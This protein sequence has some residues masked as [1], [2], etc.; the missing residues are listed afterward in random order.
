MCLF[1]HDSIWARFLHQQII[2]HMR[3]RFPEWVH[4]QVVWI[5]RMSTLKFYWIQENQTA[6]YYI[7]FKLETKIMNC[8][9][10]FSK[11]KYNQ[12]NS[13]EYAIQFVYN[14]LFI[15][16][17]CRVW[18]CFYWFHHV[19]PILSVILTKYHYAILTDYPGIQFHWYI[20]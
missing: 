5:L 10:V 16:P 15:G 19:F 13:S 11:K 4:C 8:M 6:T 12:V 18:V 14:F 1:L 9:S 3:K 20:S 2:S 17:L 7:S